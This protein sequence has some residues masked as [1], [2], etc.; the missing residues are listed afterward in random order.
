VDL[1]ST[2][3]ARIPALRINLSR[4][5]WNSIHRPTPNDVVALDAQT[6]QL[7]W[8][9]SYSP[10]DL[11]LRRNRGLAIL[12]GTL[13]LGT[14][15]AHLIA[16]DAYSGKLKWN[17]TVANSAD[18]LC[19]GSQCYGLTLAPLVVLFTGAFA[20]SAQNPLGD[21]YALDARTGQLL[22]RRTLPGK[23]RVPR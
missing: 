23:F 11:G 17:T 19:S 2:H 3:S 22:W 20:Q 5:G 13:F 7:I 9:Y 14:L 8:M 12:G 21:F 15:D 6:G 1:A 4:G 10:T 18:P 16:I